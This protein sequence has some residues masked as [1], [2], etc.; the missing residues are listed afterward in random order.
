MNLGIADAA[1]LSRRI[2]ED[3]LE[4]YGLKRHAAARNAIAYSERGRR[5]MTSRSPA[6][7]LGVSMTLKMLERNS[8]VRQGVMAKLLELN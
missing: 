5:A 2:L 8:S 4:D 1:D 7:R 6:V 3:D